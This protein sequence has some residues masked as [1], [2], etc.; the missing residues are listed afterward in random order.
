MP[1]ISAAAAG[2]SSL[3]D[4]PFRALISF[5]RL[6]GVPPLAGFSLKWWVLSACSSLSASLALSLVLVSLVSAGWYLWLGLNSALIA[7]SYSASSAP[8]ALLT[9][10]SPLVI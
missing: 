8:L 5:I 6:A 4:V 10:S 3:L 2:A 9:Q 7:N 1:L